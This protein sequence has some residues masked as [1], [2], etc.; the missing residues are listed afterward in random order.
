MKPLYK[1]TIVIWSEGDPTDNYELTD[2]AREADQGLMYCS[3][4]KAKKV[5]NP[6]SGWHGIFREG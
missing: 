6:E 2:M 4:M 5:N 3:S 1:T